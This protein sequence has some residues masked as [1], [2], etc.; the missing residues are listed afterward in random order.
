[1]ASVMWLFYFR[2]E[3]KEIQSRIGKSSNVPDLDDIPSRIKKKIASSY[4][5]LEE[6]KQQLQKLEKLSGAVSGLG[7]L[8][9]SPFLKSGTIGSDE[10]PN[11]GRGTIM[12]D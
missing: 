10:K 7:T 12:H 2:E 6:R 1:M 9:I 11:G 8:G 5:E 3:A 4:R